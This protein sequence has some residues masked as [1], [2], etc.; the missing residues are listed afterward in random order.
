MPWE[1]K[2]F[3]FEFLVDALLRG[4][5]ASRAAFYKELFYLGSLSPN[6]IREKENMNPIDDPNGDKY[7]VQANMVPIDK[8]G[9]QQQAPPPEQPKDNSNL[10]D[11]IKKI[12]DR[13]KENL[14][15]A[16]QREKDKFPDY[17][18]D[19][20]RDFSTY[21]LKELSGGNNHEPRN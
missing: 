7:F 5:S 4:D 1:R 17:L 12:A 6:D 13:N 20:F 16:Y 21:M 10:D 2:T 14:I 8:A 15:R 19:Y 18:N 11:A 3:F 9:K